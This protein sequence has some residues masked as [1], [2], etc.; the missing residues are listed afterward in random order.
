MPVAFLIKE[1]ILPEHSPKFIEWLNVMLSH[2]EFKVYREGKFKECECDRVM[3]MNEQL[4]IMTRSMAKTANADAPSMYP[5]KG[6]HKSQ[7]RVK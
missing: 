4:M 1:V 2:E 5:L 3:R 7:K 6:D